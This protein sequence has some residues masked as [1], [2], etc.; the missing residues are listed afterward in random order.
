MMEATFKCQ[1]KG[2]PFAFADL[3]LQ[4]ASRVNKTKALVMAEM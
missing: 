4:K 3:F 2:S 1:P